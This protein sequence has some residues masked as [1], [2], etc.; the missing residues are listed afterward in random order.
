MKP[1]NALLAVYFLAQWTAHWSY[2]KA[3]DF[4]PVTDPYTGE[5]SPM[6]SVPAIACLGRGEKEMSKKFEV[7]ADAQT[8]LEKCTDFEP[9]GWNPG[10]TCANKKIIKIEEKELP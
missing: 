4:D 8:F 2:H 10:T 7:L 9:N 5:L 1:A 3:C 6:V